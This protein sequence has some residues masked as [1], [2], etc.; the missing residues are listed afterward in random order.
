MQEL[1]KM[2]DKKPKSLLVTPDFPNASGG[3]SI[4]LY[5]IAKNL[6]PESIV[7]L[8][9]RHFKDKDFDE[10]SN[11]KIYRGNFYFEGKSF[12]SQILNS[13]FLLF[14]TL[15]ITLKEKI[16][17]IQ[18]GVP[19]PIS[20]VAFIVKIILGKPYVVYTYAMDVIRPQRSWLRVKILRIGLKNADTVFTIS[21]YTKGKLLELGIPLRKIVKIPIGVDYGTF[22]PNINS[23]KIEEKY[24]LKNKKV[25]LTVGRLVRRKGQDKV[26]KVMPHV[27]E[28]VSNVVYIII[29]EGEDKSRLKNLVE[30]LKL[31]DRVIFT[32]YIPN[33]ELP[34][35]Y[36][37]CD[38]FIMPSREIPEEGDAEGFGIVYLEAN[39]CG[40]PVI[41]GKSGGIP[42]AIMDGKTGLLVDPHSEEEIAQ[43][44]IKLLSDEDYAQKLG[45][46][47]LDRVRKELTWEKT[48]KQVTNEIEDLR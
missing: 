48:A 34:C 14:L 6:P 22:N 27:L 37:A 32:G 26:I 36:N 24:N 45:Q 38:V 5:N 44:L 16:D 19:L 20:F 18:C 13:I 40:K 17:I 3:I 8:A 41:G 11:F 2:S 39:A 7:V 42:D 10:N 21:E 47:G 25:I 33:K 4:I 28:K 23:K 12:I 1:T 35:Y 30:E 9:P 15:K 46:N 29:G 31:G 43:A